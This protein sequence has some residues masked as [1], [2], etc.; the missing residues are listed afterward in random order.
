MVLESLVGPR[1]AEKNKKWLFVYGL[2]YA[3]IGA[4]VSLWVFKSQASMVMVF[5]TVI[6]AFPLFYKTLNRGQMFSHFADDVI[7]TQITFDQIIFG[8]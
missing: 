6:A 5:L 2:V 8:T 3:V 1:K 7:Q 4:F